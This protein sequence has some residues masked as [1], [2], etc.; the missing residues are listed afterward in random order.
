M[1]TSSLSPWGQ[2]SDRSYARHTLVSLGVWVNAGPVTTPQGP[3]DS[4][5]HRAYA[6]QGNK[7]RTAQQIAK[8]IDALGG[9]LN[10][11]TAKEYTVYNTKVLDE[12][13]YKPR[14]LSLTSSQRRDQP[15]ELEKEKKVVLQ[16]IR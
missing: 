10:A 3:R 12:H 11:Q 15:V 14:T 6:F 13:L 2:G 4:P 9:H 8:E 7:P 1:I 5:F 16:E